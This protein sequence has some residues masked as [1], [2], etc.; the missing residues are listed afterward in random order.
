MTAVGCAL[1]N[2]EVGALAARG[3][4]RGVAFEDRPSPGVLHRAMSP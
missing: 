2:P 3:R 4:L 1:S